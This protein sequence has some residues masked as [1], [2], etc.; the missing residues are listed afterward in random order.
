K[1]AFHAYLVERR[2]EAINP[3]GTG[4]KAAAHYVL[5]LPAGSQVVVR[6]RLVAA[7][8]APRA[9]FGIGFERTFD[10]CIR[11]AEEFYRSRMPAQLDDEERRVSRQG[12]AGLLWSKQFYHYD[13]RAW[14][15][16]DPAQPPP[17]VTRQAGRNAEWRHLY[18][19]DVVSMPDKWEYP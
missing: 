13:T 14:L 17:P 4:T 15:E 19:R 5:C 9:P 1:D 10:A 18:N 2:R 6:L 3:A 11:E 16:G 8:E 12:Y 7:G